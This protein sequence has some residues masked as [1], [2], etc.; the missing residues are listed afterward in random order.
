MPEKFEM[1]HADKFVGVPTEYADKQEIAEKNFTKWFEAPSDREKPFELE[2]TAKDIELINFCDEAVWKY[3]Q[4]YGREKNI[5]LPMDHIH[6]LKKDGVEAAT[7]G[8]LRIGLH[9]M[10]RGKIAVDRDPSDT[11]F[12]LITFHELFHAKSYQAGQIQTKEGDFNVSKYRGGFM[13]VARDGK[14]TY[15][16]DVEEAIVG[17]MTQRFFDEILL[18]D[19]LFI[20]EIKERA[21]N[22]EPFDISRQEEQVAGKKIVADLFAKNLGK[23]AN[24]EEIMEM[25]IKTQVTGNLLPVA[26][27][28]EDTYGKGSF[29]KL[30]EA[31]GRVDKVEKR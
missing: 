29:R 15:F 10:M 31:T 18:K 6:V 3:M 27:L 9:S 14:R 2:K 23:F 17:H 13:V 19:P 28:F 1:P 30:G 11:Q 26:R 24:K 5:R 25:F 20:P 21:K 12:S 16:D 7:E 4:G 8:R 22:G